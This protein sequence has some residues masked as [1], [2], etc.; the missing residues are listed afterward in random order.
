MDFKG[1]FTQ[2]FSNGLEGLSTQDSWLVLLFMFIPFLL[3]LLFGRGSYR[4]KYKRMK[5]AHDQK[6]KDYNLLKVEYDTLQNQYQTLEKD[7]RQANQEVADITAN[8]ERQTDE[9]NHLRTQLHNASERV[10]ELETANATYATDLEVM[11]DQ[12]ITLQTQNEHLSS[13]ISDGTTTTT[14]II[15]P[16]SGATPTHLGV[17]EEDYSETKNRIET[18]EER[19]DQIVQENNRLKYELS[20]IRNTSISS[21]PAIVG[22]AIVDPNPGVNTLD[23]V[24]FDEETDG[25]DEAVRDV[26]AV[27]ENASIEFEPGRSEKAKIAIREAMGVHIKVATVDEKN[28]LKLING[29]GPFIEEKLNDI[30]IYT[31]EQITQLD[32]TMIDLVTDAIQ[33]FPGRIDRD[34]WV[35]QAKKLL[36]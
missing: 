13:N 7:L 3:G 1:F 5:R 15:E 11:H 34:D 19:L 8:L 31:F 12:L 21:N 29:I 4:G 25:A 32:K 14:T 26:N 17:M 28:D 20:E 22:E 2:L 23:E 30:G 16:P 33:F 9:K 27:A 6:V 24:Y 10:R 35:G 36:S 18:I